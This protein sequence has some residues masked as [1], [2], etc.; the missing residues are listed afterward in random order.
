MTTYIFN[1]DDSRSYKT[2]GN[3]LHAL[4]IQG[5]ADVPKLVVCNRKG[6]FTAIF[7]LNRLIKA[8]IPMMEVV[9]AGF[10]VIS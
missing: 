3:L 1:I 4:N 7:T 6:R 2:E 5:L 10:P 9:E 8:D